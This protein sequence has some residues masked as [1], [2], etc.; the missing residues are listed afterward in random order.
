[1]SSLIHGSPTPTN[2][3][4]VFS[5]DVLTKERKATWKSNSENM[6]VQTARAVSHFS[7]KLQKTQAEMPRL[8]QKR[9]P[10]HIQQHAQPIIK[11]EPWF[12]EVIQ[13]EEE[14][15]IQGVYSSKGRSTK[16]S[17]MSWIK[18]VIAAEWDRVLG[19]AMGAVILVPKKSEQAKPLN[20]HSPVF[21]PKKSQSTS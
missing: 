13:K 15:S 17:E 10:F 16:S 19:R 7:G 8:E 20:P 1:M 6:P 3:S 18:E 21:V 2:L 5:S 11:K 14:R 4:Y 9:T 12:L